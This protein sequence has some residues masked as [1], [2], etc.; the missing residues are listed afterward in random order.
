MA[1]R[2]H[3]IGYSAHVRCCAIDKNFEYL[4]SLENVGVSQSFSFSR[5]VIK[6]FSL[7]A[8]FHFFNQ[9]IA[10]APRPEWAN[11]P[12]FIP[13]RAHAIGTMT[14]IA[15][16]KQGFLWFGSHY[17]IHRF[18][19]Y[20]RIIYS[21]NPK[22][23]SAIAGGQIKD[24]VVSNSNTV[25]VA[26]G[27][28][29]L[30]AYLPLA[31]AFTNF[32]HQE[33]NKESIPSNN[34]FALAVD[35]VGGV[36][37]GTGNGLARV[38]DISH[39]IKRYQIHLG[40]VNSEKSS[41]G[42][43]VIRA[44]FLDA[45]DQLWV[46]HELGLS[47]I[48]TKTGHAAPLRLQVKDGAIWQGAVSSIY[49]T[50]DGTVWIGTEKQGLGRISDGRI[51]FYPVNQEK[52]KSLKNPNIKDM[53]QVK[54]KLWVGTYGGGISIIDLTDYK[55]LQTIKA[56]TEDQDSGVAT[57]W[58]FLIDD[59][60]LLWIS[61]TGGIFKYN[62]DAD[63][64]VFLKKQESDPRSL[65]FNN[66]LAVFEHSDGNIWISYLSNGLDILDASFN[67]I[68]HLN[69]DTTR[70]N[71]FSTHITDIVED[72]TGKVWLASYGEG[73]I[74]VDSNQ[75]TMTHYTE[76]LLN[77]K[78]SVLLHDQGRLFIG[79]HEGL[80][81][82][83]LK[84]NTM[85]A[86]TKV[87]GE[88]TGAVGRIFDMVLYT[89][90]S[91]WIASSNGLYVLPPGEQELL[92]LPS[93][94]DKAGG[95]LGKAFMELEVDD[96]GRL[97]LRS[98]GYGVEV[99]TDWDG[100][101]GKFKS[102]FDSLDMEDKTTGHL[103]SDKLGRLWTILGV[104][105]ENFSDF[106]PLK[107][108]DGLNLNAH[109]WTNSHGKTRSGLLL[110][111]TKAGLNVFDPSTVKLWNYHPPIVATEILVEGEKKTLADDQV[112][113][114]PPNNRGVSIEFSA[115]D[116]SSPDSNRYEYRLEGYDESWQTSSVDRRLV[117]FMN[118]APG[119][120]E[121]RVRGTNHHGK[122]SDNELVIPIHQL[123][124]WYQTLW[125]KAI[126][127][128]LIL[129]LG[130]SIHEYRL[131]LLKAR[132][133]LLKKMVRERTEELASA[134]GE[135]A[136]ANSNLE[137]ANNEL[138]SLAKELEL[139]ATTDSLTGLANVRRFREFLNKVWSASIREK[140]ELS[141]ILL[142]V[143]Y[144]KRYNDTYGHQ[145]GDDCLQSVAQVLKNNVHR[146][147][148]LAARYGG[149]E[150]VIIL[151]NTGKEGALQVAERVRKGVEAL[152]VLHESSDVAKHVTVSLGVATTRP[153]AS[154]TSD[155]LIKKA[156]DE[157]YV[158]KENGRNRVSAGNLE[159]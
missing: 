78:I 93:E 66:I 137:N 111:S 17:D 79:T 39:Q 153:D 118:L 1:R 125:F 33:N 90:N 115:L 63:A 65:S 77:P 8:L 60:G 156:D 101:N 61:T 81:V 145:K 26:T 9:S 88:T 2:I 102:L 152:T 110:Y 20:K 36:W 159:V 150:F 30:S 126:V 23:P 31:D 99:M 127:L 123:A 97:I 19:G 141:V 133:N 129:I 5:F 112:L 158:A 92:Y 12:E 98:V 144:F 135:L 37:V 40:G 29:G 15:Q 105:S 154:R 25:W 116:F 109:S 14:S 108:I 54:D 146:P 74:Q 157:L 59:S 11:E 73:I 136:S 4:F 35:R 22:D 75:E 131:R 52:Q 113:N 151:S 42:S 21:P 56:S 64:F 10:A 69:P 121:L 140:Q 53:I 67:K 49:Q 85:Q 117:S 50:S 120:Y 24:I 89:D 13:T 16:D 139:L 91:L 95:L 147:L 55:L 104:F 62:P 27:A 46:G 18:D 106:R 124:A 45:N 100:S 155:A 51:L 43:K 80:N 119:K 149:E 57:V 71:W 143:D 83:D 130:Y 7:I 103:S 114:L 82:L 94:P 58:R 132:T 70:D 48:N 72:G 134:N 148:D 122:W 38:D 44:L 138:Q 32:E 34:V 86:I 107:S 68:K 28:N 96:Q 41:T 128:L 47:Q 6:I 84:T 142:D 76:G 3:V 87:K